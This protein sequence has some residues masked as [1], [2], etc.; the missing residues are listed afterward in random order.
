M[1][2]IEIKK[3]EF[4]VIMDDKTYD[5]ILLAIA[6]NSVVAFV[7]FTDILIYGIKNSL[8]EIDHKER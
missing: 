6:E 4:T 7:P 2:Q 5:N 3:H 8:V 1:S